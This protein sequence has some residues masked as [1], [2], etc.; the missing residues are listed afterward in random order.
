MKQ[1][2]GK[3]SGS[4]PFLVNITDNEL[5][6]NSSLKGLKID[7]PAPLG[8]QAASTVPLKFQMDHRPAVNGISRDVI[9]IAMAK[10]SLPDICARRQDRVAGR[11]SRAVLP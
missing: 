8:K 7:L 11:S 6:V 4:T 10:I 5:K 9:D 2:V 1:L 3:L